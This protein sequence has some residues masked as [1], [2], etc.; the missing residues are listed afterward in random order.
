[1]RLIEAV[2]LGI[3]V[4]CHQ[5]PPKI[6]SWEKV[7]SPGLTYRMEVDTE[8]PLIVHGLRFSLNTPG[9]KARPELAGHTINEE[10]TVKGRLTP[11]QM[12]AQDGAIAAIN[13][14][15]FSFTQGAP[16]GLMVREGELL[17]TP[18]KS[19]AVFA[20]GPKQ[21]AIGFGTTVAT[22]IPEDK[23]RLHIDAV[24]QP[25]GTNQIVVYTPSEGTAINAAPNVTAVLSLTNPMWAPSTVVEATLEYVLPDAKET[26]VPP[27]KALLVATGTKMQAIAA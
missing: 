8:T 11:A 9:L 26:K 21:S 13:G 27:G 20:W 19:R 7:V 17:T 5:A 15:F 10:G 22:L 3:L 23:G 25:C 14:D 4:P 1:M 24:N 18:E 16:I 6:Q 12:A 2:L